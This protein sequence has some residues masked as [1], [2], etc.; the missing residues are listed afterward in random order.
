M[1]VTMNLTKITA[2]AG[3]A[4]LLKSVVKRDDNRPAASGAIG[5]YTHPG[6]PAGV[7]LGSAV[8]DLGLAIG[9]ETTREQAE[10]VFSRFAHPVTGTP[11]GTPPRQLHEARAQESPDQ[12]SGFDLTFSIPKSVSVI[13][14]V[15]DRGAQATIMTAH[16]DAITR[17]L[18]W[19]ETEVAS[20]RQGRAGVASATMRGVIA[21]AYDHFETRDGDPHLHTHVALANRVRRAFDGK[22]LT[23]DGRTAYRSAVA[24]SELHENALLDLLNERLGMVFVERSRPDARSARSVVADAAGFPPELVDRFST[25]RFALRQRRETLE[26]QWLANHPDL[27][28][29]PQTVQAAL[30][31]QAWRETRK[32]KD[33]VAAPLSALTRRWRDQ[34]RRLGHD[35][36]DLIARVLDHEPAP[37]AARQ[38]RGN[39]VTQLARLAIAHHLTQGPGVDREHLARITDT[40]VETWLDHHDD[41]DTRDVL[42]RSVHDTLA[43]R[44]A[45]W[46]R[47]N[48]RAEV[49]RLTRLVRFRPDERQGVIDRITDA[50]IALCVPITPHRYELPAGADSD[51]R[52]AYAGHTVFDNPNLRRFTAQEVLDAEAFL[53]SL[54]DRAG[55]HVTPEEFEAL[56]AS[57]QGQTLANDQIAAVRHLA[58]DPHALTA[59]VGPAGSGKTTTMRALHDVWTAAHGPGSVLGVA[60]SARA[61][62]ELAASVGIDAHTLAMLL[63]RNS[64][65]ARAS[66]AARRRDYMAALNSAHPRRRAAAA[67]GLAVLDV[68]DSSYTLRHGTLVVVDEASMC[69]TH[70]LAALGRLVVAAGAKVVLVGDPAQLDA[71]DAGGILGW[72]DRQGK[73]AHLSSLFRFDAPW[74]ASASLR[75]RDGDATVLYPDNDGPHTYADAGRIHDGDSDAMLDA[76]YD[77]VRT[78]Q[79]AG[80]TAVLVA[81]TN[82]HVSDLNLRTTLDRRAAGEVDTTRLVTLRAGQD[83]GVGDLVYARLNDYRTL[84]DNSGVAIHNGDLLR[85]TAID[86]HGS[87]TCRRVDTGANIT[88]PRGYL[89]QHCDLG[90]ALTAHRAQGI[91]VDEAH[92]FVPYGARMTREL[93]YVAMTRGR[94]NNTA[95]IGLPDAADLAHENRS[96]FETDDDGARHLAM[97][98]GASILARALAAVGA[99]Q[100]AHEQHDTEI[101]A[102]SNLGRL[103]A[104]HETLASHAVAPRLATHLTWLHPEVDFT[105]SPAWDA[106]VSTFRHAYAVNP[107]RALRLLRISPAS[108]ARTTS[109]GTLNL[110]DAGP[111]EAPVDTGTD[112]ASEPGHVDPTAITQWRLAGALVD[113]AA[114]AADDPA[115]VAGLVVRIQTDD[116]PLA[117]LARQCEALISRRVAD[118]AR[119]LDDDPPPWLSDAPPAPD[120]DAAPELRDKWRHAML[121]VAIYRDNWQVTAPT[122]LGPVPVGDRR[123]LRHFEQTHDLLAHWHDGGPKP[124]PDL[125]RPIAT[126]PYADIDWEALD[127]G[128]HDLDLPPGALFIDA[129]GEPL[130]DPA[131][132]PHDDPSPTYRTASPWRDD[133]REPRTQDPATLDRITAANAAAWDYWQSCAAAP[134]S[135]VL[136]YLT[137]RGLRDVVPHAHAPAGWTTTIDHLRERGFTS[138]ELLDS[139]LATRARTGRLIDR[140]RDRLPLPIYDG[141]GRI[142]GFTARANPDETTARRDTPK[143]LNTPTTAAY[144]KSRLLYGLTPEARQRLAVGATP[145][146][147]EG[148]MDATA[149]DTLGRDDLVPL[150]ACGTAVTAAHLSAIARHAGSLSGLVVAFD[151]DA[152]G[153]AAAAR[154]WSLLGPGDAGPVRQVTWSGAKDPGELIQLGKTETLD[155][156][157]A[158]SRPLAVALVEHLAAT[159]IAP[160]T[161]EGQVLLLRAVAAAVAPTRNTEAI[162]AATN[163]L[164]DSFGPDS[165]IDR[166]I[167]TE[168]FAD[169]R[170]KVGRTE[171]FG[172]GRPSTGADLT[173]QT[174]TMT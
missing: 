81:A 158:H 76:A 77:A 67:R 30:D 110:W 63:A 92:L 54:T 99:E 171:E 157:L 140:F 97:P 3:V 168:E 57:W 11:L 125:S 116:A 25:R 82:D 169:A 50:A 36:R 96:A 68:E 55:A 166:T 141:T 58:G 32:P 103:V 93:L 34:L 139:G 39:V 111:E 20:T 98:T 72:L 105:A 16:R 85:L 62:H 64:P 66:R 37:T 142:A 119:Q 71:I 73:T 90:Y 135:W 109:Q 117:D 132:S 146:L 101:A 165:A 160:E 19:F 137:D 22:W 143:Y 104:E 134:P 5:Y 150:A 74:E 102:H 89:A 95:W 35:A 65:D 59:L 152:A 18:D 41:G 94:I 144:D 161:I 100:T 114:V 61:A 153:Q 173:D 84:R 79:R 17:T 91:T 128:D 107:D 10:R 115:Y 28:T 108:G 106:L 124:G 87:A 12:V 164:A 69:S 27:D 121:A 170:P 15:A 56:L 52:L 131:H 155:Q 130:S 145:I 51:P 78:A 29:I 126:D 129:A 9:D 13:W 44:R 8:P 7:W 70:D 21:I 46:S 127:P 53:D 120:P 48:A 159:A 33:A 163:A 156:S 45:T 113:P 88:L 83:A 80:R 172:L 42:A 2:D 112:P 14:G 26:R 24:M 47:F 38:I 40:D 147:V 43:R 174:V 154:L 167:V 60:P 138:D 136:A 151:A 162:T 86:D 1:S 123:R 6:T 31:A 75:L 23:L 49:E 122:P 118:L 149:I 148:P 4:Y 133:A